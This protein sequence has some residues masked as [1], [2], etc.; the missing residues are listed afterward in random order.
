MNLVVDVSLPVPQTESM[1]RAFKRRRKPV[2]PP[3]PP[4]PGSSSSG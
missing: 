1:K 4:A 3:A 2:S